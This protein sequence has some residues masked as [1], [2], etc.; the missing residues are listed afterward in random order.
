MERLLIRVALQFDKLS[1]G[2]LSTVAGTEVQPAKIPKREEAIA[3]TSLFAVE[4]HFIVPR[5]G[6]TKAAG[7]IRDA[8]TLP[9]SG[10]N[11]NHLYHAVIEVCLPK[12]L[13]AALEN[14][15]ATGLTMVDHPRDTPVS[16]QSPLEVRY[17]ANRNEA[18]SALNQQAKHRWSKDC[19][20]PG[21]A[22]LNSL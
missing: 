16:S 13:S 9:I 5:F 3:V 20:K 19:F 14:A 17:L 1:D 18:S 7:R 2:S 15:G 6:L 21:L 12:R 4:H 11:S 10:F 8:L 22:A